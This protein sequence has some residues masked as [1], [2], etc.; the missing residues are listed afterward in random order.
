MISRNDPHPKHCNAPAAPTGFTP[1]CT[2]GQTRVIP[3]NFSAGPP[4]PRQVVG[5]W[6]FEHP[7]QVY[8]GVYTGVNLVSQVY[9]G[10]YPGVNLSGNLKEIHRNYFS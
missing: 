8:P 3:G 4:V 1:G 9:P 5:L 6:F 7:G 10:V 2:P